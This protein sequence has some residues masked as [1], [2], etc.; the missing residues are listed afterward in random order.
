MSATIEAPANGGLIPIKIEVR[1]EVVTSNVGKFRELVK[2][3]LSTINRDLKTDEQFGQAEV[4]VKTLKGAEDAIRSAKEK[5]LADAESLHALFSELDLTGEEIRKPRL[6]LESL[7]KKRKDEV[8]AEIVDEAIKRI[9]L[10]TATRAR[11]L[12]LAGIQEAIKGKRTLESMRSSVDAVVKKYNL[13]IGKTRAVLDEFERLH[14][15]S[16]IMDRRDLEVK[17]SENVEAE[18]SRR[19]DLKRAQDE[20]ARLAN[21]AK[22]AKAEL[23]ASQPQP[24]AEVAPA[25]AEAPV[26]AQFIPPARRAV[27][28]AG[29]EL[30]ID[31]NIEWEEFKAVCFAAAASMKAAREKLKHPT[32]Q[33]KALV[34]SNALNAAWRGIS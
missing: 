3:A 20:N 34:F 2:T 29:I 12:C 17:L 14:G 31:Q 1:G 26:Q 33:S 25:K 10:D 22:N 21:E 18:L 19:I 7:I 16:L 15:N 24:V 4:D 5:A 28:P 6:E 13:E 27:A 8:K 9:D 30:A 11:G 32:N 23:A